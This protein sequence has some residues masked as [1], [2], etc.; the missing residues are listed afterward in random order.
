MSSLMNLLLICIMEEK[1]LIY[2]F[3]KNEIKLNNNN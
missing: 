1:Y 3:I 2:A